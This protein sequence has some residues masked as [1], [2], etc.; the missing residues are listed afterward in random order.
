MQENVQICLSST[1]T[2]SLKTKALIT[3]EFFQNNLKKST[4]EF[5]AHQSI[6]IYLQIFKSFNKFIFKKLCAKSNLNF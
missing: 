2:D 5:E 6:F 4:N 3:F 1:K